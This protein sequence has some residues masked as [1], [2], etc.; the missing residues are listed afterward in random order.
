MIKVGLARG[1]KI[2][3]FNVFPSNRDATGLGNDS[4]RIPELENKKKSGEKRK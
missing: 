3:I 4:L 2:H 1:L